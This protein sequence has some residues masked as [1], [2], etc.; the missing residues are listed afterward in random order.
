MRGMARSV[1]AG[2]GLV[3]LGA[4][5]QAAP[6]AADEDELI[7]DAIRLR[8]R[9]DDHMAQVELQRAY[10]IAHSP[11][12]A[13]QLGFAEQALGMWPQAEAHVT[14]ALRGTDDRWIRKNRET[15]EESL[16]TIRAH[17][18]RVEIVGGTPGAQV[19]INGQPMGLLPM[20]AAVPVSA[21]PV[22]IQLRTPGAPLAFKTVNVAAGEH[23][24]V[25]F[26]ARVGSAA[27]QA[28][29]PPAAIAPVQPMPNGALDL[30]RVDA[31]DGDGLQ[32][33]RYAGV[34]L[35]VGG[36]AV[37][38]GGVAAS[39][40]A[41]HKFDAINADAAADRPYNEQNGNWKNYETAATVLYVVGAGAVIGGTVLYIRGRGRGEQGEQGEQGEKGNSPGQPPI[42]VSLK[43]QVAPGRA[44]AALSVRF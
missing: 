3:L 26:A 16:A 17:V 33:R 34:G 20:V 13:A 15:L 22:E 41:K 44:G 28:L 11:R 43:P 12:A 36:L 9:G 14:E 29:P 21:G 1:V 6:E 10:D 25:P 23:A 32:R 24:R 27:A 2:L 42:S 8:K 30:T 19:T 4:T 5:A 40:V 31:R 35:L 18:G 38:G 37:A 39:L 7:R